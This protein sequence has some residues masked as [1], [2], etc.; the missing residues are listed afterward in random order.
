MVAKSKQ[1]KDAGSK[2]WWAKPTPE[3]AEM[4]SFAATRGLSGFC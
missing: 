2:A 4:R 1:L 3:D